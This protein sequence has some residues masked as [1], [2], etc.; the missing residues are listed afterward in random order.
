MPMNLHGGYANFRK[1]DEKE[2]ALFVEAM[3]NLLGVHYT[4]LCVSSQVVNGIN[5]RF[6]CE[7]KVVAPDPVP[8]NA[9]VTIYSPIQG[10]PVVLEIRTVT[11]V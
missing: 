7:A 11:I 4:L 9:L 8:Y 5:Y 2:K 10:E 1:I 6:L 3:K